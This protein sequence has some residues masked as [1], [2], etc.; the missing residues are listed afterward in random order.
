MTL[1]EI[2][3]MCLEILR[4][5]SIVDDER[6]DIRLLKDWINL[7]RAQFIKN[8]VSQ[9]P[10][11]RINLNLYQTIEVTVDPIDVIDAGD[12]PY[13]NSTTQLYE[14]VESTTTIPTIIEGKSGP[15]ILS[16]ESEDLM[17]L[18]FSVV[19]YNHLRFAGNGKFNSRIIFGA[20]RDN[21]IYFKYDAFFDTYTTVI[22]RAVFEDPRQV[23]TE[24][25]PYDDETTRYPADL[26]LIEY[27]KNAIL[28]I[29]LKAFLS[30]VPDEEND[31]TGEI[32]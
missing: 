31:A 18:P 11:D 21:K 25:V 20:I 13:T 7:K 17:K 19:D 23:G 5:G 22:L 28:Q 2:A 30:G 12:Y 8:S 14:I 1:N 3:Y 15:L 32:K 9:N 27:I 16:L 29:D 26:G 10:S 6:L 24:A 4:Q